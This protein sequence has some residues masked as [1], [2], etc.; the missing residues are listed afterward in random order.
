MLWLCAGLY[1]GESIR[2]FEPAMETRLLQLTSNMLFPAK[3]SLL[4]RCMHVTVFQGVFPRVFLTSQSLWDSNTGWSFT[5][6][7]NTAIS[8]TLILFCFWNRFHYCWNA[9]HYLL[10]L[11]DDKQKKIRWIQRKVIKYGCRLMRSVVQVFSIRQLTIT[12]ISAS[13]NITLLTQICS[14]SPF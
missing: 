13:S 10:A 3:P 4:S 7:L 6:K 8:S 12:D 11:T 14:I 5:C 9:C 2:F 1:G